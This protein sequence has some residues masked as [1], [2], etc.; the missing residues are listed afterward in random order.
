MFHDVAMFALLFSVFAIT[1][2]PD[3]MTIFSRGLSAGHWAALPF[4]IGVILAKLSLL[5]LVIIGL[6]ALAQRFAS[7]FVILKFVGA[8][9]L[10]WAGIRMWR[11]SG[12]VQVHA[13][14][15]Q[16]F[17]R[18]SVMGYILGISNP[19]AVIFYVA[20]LP[21]VLD[22]QTIDISTYL[23]LCL[24][25][26]VIMVA[27]AALYAVLA[28]RLRNLFTSPKAQK[29]TNRVAGGVMI[30]SSLWVASR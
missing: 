27:V 26:A 2:G 24:T 30:G 23:A 18:D 21:A 16:K 13:L 12:E 4:T 15:S 29:T 7:L 17:W 10:L 20:L 19:H 22:M 8:A 25:L 6:A 3:T 14:A 11:K 1:P 28:G 9:Y 5:T